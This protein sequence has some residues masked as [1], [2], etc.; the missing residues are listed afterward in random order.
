MP[1]VSNL[2]QKQEGWRQGRTLR[3]ELVS[4]R[5]EKHKLRKVRTV[6]YSMTIDAW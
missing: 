2:S 6:K 4:A 1:K 3:T 5:L